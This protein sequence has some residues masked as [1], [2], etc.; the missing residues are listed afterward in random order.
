M[1][2]EEL[3]VRLCCRLAAVKRPVWRFE[4]GASLHFACA[5]RALTARPCN[6]MKCCSWEMSKSLRA[7]GFGGF[8]ARGSRQACRVA[9]R[10]IRETDRRS[11]LPPNDSDTET[12]QHTGQPPDFA[13]GLTGCLSRQYPLGST[14]CKRMTRGRWDQLERLMHQLLLVLQYLRGASFLRTSLVAPLLNRSRLA[15]RATQA[16]TG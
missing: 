12:D 5:S 16:Y 9:R 8:D 6:T 11:P 13:R 1:S 15:V 2:K 4:P 3:F 14:S 7:A 10:E